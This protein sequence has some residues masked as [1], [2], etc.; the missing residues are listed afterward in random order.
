MGKGGSSL[1]SAVESLCFAIVGSMVGVLDFTESEQP[2]NVGGLGTLNL[3]FLYL[4][5][6]TT[7]VALTVPPTGCSAKWSPFRVSVRG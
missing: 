2:G 6:V 1:P 5:K 7:K 3:K 4:T